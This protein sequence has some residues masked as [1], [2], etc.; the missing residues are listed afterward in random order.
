MLL[1][2]LRWMETRDCC[3]KG[4]GTNPFD[5]VKNEKRIATGNFML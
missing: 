2:L 5:V 1:L 3:V 4:A